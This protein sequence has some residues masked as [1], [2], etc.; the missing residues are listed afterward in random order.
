MRTLQCK[1]ASQKDII[2]LLLK[3]PDV[4]FLMPSLKKTFWA[5]AVD[6][7]VFVKNRSPAA[8]L[9]R[10]TTPLQAGNQVMV[11][12]PKE[13]RRKWDKKANKMFLVGYSENIKGYRL[14]DPDLRKI[15]IAR[16]VVVVESVNDNIV[17][18][19]KNLPTTILVED[20]QGLDVTQDQLE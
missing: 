3:K 8:G 1:M 14:Y 16:D 2:D 5:E 11:H 12:I 13:K 20:K 19:E 4:Y 10:G 15:V 7:A 6:T 9:D 17:V 18:I